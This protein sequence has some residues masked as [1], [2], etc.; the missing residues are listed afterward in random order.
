MAMGT[1]VGRVRDRLRQE[2]NGTI[3]TSMNRSTGMW[4]TAC[5]LLSVLT[6]GGHGCALWLPS[7]SDQS[8]LKAKMQPLASA[9]DAIDIEVYFI[10]RRIGDP[11][12]GEGFW[13]TLHA[14][15]SVDPEVRERLKKDGFRFA[16]SA[17]RPPRAMQALMALSSDSDP[18]RRALMQRYSLPAGQETYLLVSALADGVTLERTHRGEPQQLN[19]EQPH[20][21]LRVQAEKIQDGWAKLVIVPEVRHGRNQLRPRATDQDWRFDQGQESLV[22][23]E[24]RLSAE[25]NIGEILVL[26]LAPSSENSLAK[27][28]F[29]GDESQ[30]IERLILIRVADM[31]AVNPVRVVD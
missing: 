30:G 20:F 21:H 3:G 16:M 17:S 26:G 7:I 25:V 14:I 6:A 13:S 12:I 22:L 11:L 5:L 4:I 24:D 28:Y 27:H 9:R 8:T 15:T 29:R 19:L 1:G 2:R 23:Y 31:H 18:S 10:D